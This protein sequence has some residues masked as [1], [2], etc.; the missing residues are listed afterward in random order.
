[1]AYFEEMQDIHGCIY[2]SKAGVSLKRV[3]KFLNAKEVNPDDVT[4]DKDPD[5]KP[6]AAFTV[7]NSY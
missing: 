7:Q 2:F 6:N 4:H 5:G 3:N 1:M